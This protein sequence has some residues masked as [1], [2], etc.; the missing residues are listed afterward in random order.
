MALLCV[1]SGCKT[2]TASPHVYT[3]PFKAR[4]FHLDLPQS[5][6]PPDLSPQN[7]E[8]FERL[9][10]PDP[11]VRV[12]GVHALTYRREVE[13][14]ALSFLM[15]MLPD[16]NPV[17]KDDPGHPVTSP[18]SEAAEALAHLDPRRVP[19]VPTLLTALAGDDLFV[20]QLASWTLGRLKY[21]QSLNALPPFDRGGHFLP[22]GWGERELSPAV[23]PLIGC[24]D[25]RDELVRAN[26]AW[27]LG[28]ISDP[29]AVDALVKVTDDPEASVRVQAVWALGTLGTARLG[30][31]VAQT[32]QI[33]NGKDWPWGKVTSAEVA[34]LVPA[35]RACVPQLLVRLADD[36]QQ[37][38]SAAAWTLGQFGEG[39][40][41]SL[42]ALG[43]PKPN[44]KAEPR[45]NLFT[46]QATVIAALVQAGRNSEPP[47]K[48]EVA[49]A[50]M[51]TIGKEGAQQP[52]AEAGCTWGEHDSLHTIPTRDPL[53]LRAASDTL[54]RLWDPDP[55]IRRDAALSM[56]GT[57]SEPAIR[58]LLAMLQDPSPEAR[59]IAVDVVSE[60]D[61]PRVVPALVAAAH[62]PVVC[63][64][65]ANGLA[66]RLG[67]RA[68]PILLN[69]VRSQEPT[70]VKLASIQV[71]GRFKD[72][73]V[74]SALLTAAADQPPKMALACLSL[75]ID[76]HDDRAVAPL[77]ALVR[78][79]PEVEDKR[80]A[81]LS[82][83]SL[84]T[85]AAADA[86]AAL[87]HDSDQ[88]VRNVAYTPIDPSL[89]PARPGRPTSP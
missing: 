80:T 57:T 42:P 53:A 71:L 30:Y 35:L 15:H 20:R 18:G 63:L 77:V 86:L 59:R 83:N 25:D 11:Q 27:A 49:R 66:N 68:V 45:Q 82:L 60:L 73:E 56:R 4:E 72:G 54:L 23:L 31:T 62:D 5:Q 39:R 43:T 9:Y 1:A 29:R 67:R 70:E 28:L 24:L 79:A 61:D 3:L 78:H 10:S 17:A 52:L 75:A 2:Q 58:H 51:V 38:R 76:R 16:S 69:N 87:R 19:V 26:A 37:V 12:D 8:F 47:V 34:G 41:L 89:L 88:V 48:A 32:L 74:V 33:T 50:L 22:L 7:R 64:Y 44:G 6:L 14:V 85:S 84:G 46:E 55:A 81:V 40:P 65:A 13:T 21:N 36:D